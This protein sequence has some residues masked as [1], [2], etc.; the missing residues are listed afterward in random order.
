MP[1]LWLWWCRRRARRW[2]EE[3]N[4]FALAQIAALLEGDRAS[5]REFAVG[6][7][8]AEERLQLWLRRIEVQEVGDA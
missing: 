8:A 5:A 3:R 7:A 2:R 6:R 4:L 1:S